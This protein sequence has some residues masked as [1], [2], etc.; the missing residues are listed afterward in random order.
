M[1]KRTRL[2]AAE[3]R[4][5]ILE[6]A[7][8]V[9]STRGPNASV[10][11]LAQAAGLTRTVLYHYF[12]SKEELFLAVLEDQASELLRHLA[13]V[14]GGPGSQEERARA[15]TDALLTFVEEK[16]R[17]WQLLFEHRAGEAEEIAA[18]RG[19]VHRMVMS[20]ATVLFASDMTSAGMKTDSV[21][22]AIMGELTVGAV[23]AVARWW[24]DHPAVPREE[25]S[26]AAFD[27]MWH[28]VAGL[29]ER[30]GRPD[31]NNGV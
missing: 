26:G 7:L 8:E 4:A 5:R 12:A 9:F 16:P 28:G 6:A 10:G 24:L 11:E 23:V 15:T 19:R 2:P 20:A 1:T 18:A 25:V 3:R 27:L 21:R 31:R 30:R 17:A 13:P 29:P 14:V 22:T